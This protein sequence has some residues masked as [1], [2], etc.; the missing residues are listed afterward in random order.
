MKTA[1]NLYSVRDLDEPLADIIDRVAEAGYDGVQFSGG[2]RG[3]TAEEAAALVAESGLE[4]TPAHIGYEALRDDRSTVL[5][6]YRDTVGCSG[7]VIPYLGEER[8]ASAESVDALAEETTALAEEFAAEDWTLQYHNHAHEFVDLDGETAFTRFIEHSENVL[9][10]LDVGWALVGGSDPVEL[11]EQ[12]G[13]TMELIHMK[14]MDVETE[15][16]REIGEG[17]VDMRGCAQAA[18]DAGVE[19]LI[20]EHDQPA[21]PRESIDTGAAVLNDL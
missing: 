21:D 20:Y 5:A 12:Y 19:W 4:V 14:D 8:F 6:D 7:G 18:R 2:F 11:I 10:E 1:I 15:D 9:F 16:F 3:A 17:D 13:D